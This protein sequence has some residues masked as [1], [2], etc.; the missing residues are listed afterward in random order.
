MKEA[1]STNEAPAAIGPYSQAVRAGE[2]VFYSGQIGMDPQSGQL[3]AGSVTEQAARTLDNLGAVLRA[4]GC[5]FEDV[6]RTTIFLTDLSQFAA[7]NDVYARYF[8][9]PFPARV[10]VQV[11]A[12]PR[13][14]AVEIDA[15][16]V[17]PAVQA[18]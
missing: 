8:R 12:L 2:W 15:I 16:A 7:V 11:A 1:I 6:V 3:V 5:G 4:S 18:Q 17:K 9:P 10:T 14:A 13:G